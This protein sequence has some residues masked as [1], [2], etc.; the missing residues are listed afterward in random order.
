ML[1]WRRALREG[2]GHRTVA[3]GLPTKDASQATCTEDVE[4]T[5]RD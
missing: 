5:Y 2:A 3:P 1:V 4:R